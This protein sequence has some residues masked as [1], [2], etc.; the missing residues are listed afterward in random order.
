MTQRS[1][2][3]QTMPESNL[4]EMA[5]LWLIFMGAPVIW[6]GH[7][8]VL[9]LLA[10]VTCALGTTGV[11]IE[12]GLVTLPFLAALGGIIGMAYEEWRKGRENGWLYEGHEHKSRSFMVRFGFVSSILFFTGVLFALI[13]AVTLAA[14]D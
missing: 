10:S 12:L 11:R 14:C 2:A 4:F 5:R 6:S 1:D 7:L 9:Y 3:S 8:L 13:P